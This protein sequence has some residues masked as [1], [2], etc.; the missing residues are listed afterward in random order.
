MIITNGGW[1]GCRK[2][3]TFELAF[4]KKNHIKLQAWYV[5]EKCVFLFFFLAKTPINSYGFFGRKIKNVLYQSQK[6]N[7]SQE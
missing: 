2:S 5:N 3:I 7:I 1:R 6:Y 4:E